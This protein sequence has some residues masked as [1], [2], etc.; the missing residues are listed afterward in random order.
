VADT[1]TIFALTVGCCVVAGGI[2]L[3]ALRALRH[4]SLRCQLA[5][6]TI[7]PVVAVAVSV[8]VNVEL[9]TGLVE[10]LFELSRVESEP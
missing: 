4:R 8:A 6:A 7:T 9:M 2:G 1:I 10:D 5:V 3:L